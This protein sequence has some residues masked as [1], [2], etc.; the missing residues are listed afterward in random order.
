MISPD[1]R[2]SSPLP[3]SDI[4][5]DTSHLTDF[6][7]HPSS[8]ESDVLPALQ[9]SDTVWQDEGISSRVHS[10]EVRVNKNLTVDRVEYFDITDNNGNLYTVDAL[11]KDKTGKTGA[12]DSKVVMFAS[13]LMR[14]RSRF[15]RGRLCYPATDA[16]R[17]RNHGRT[18]SHQ[19]CSARARPE[20][21]R[22]R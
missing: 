8:D 4:P 17:K 13:A 16:A 19:V 2:E 9:K 12:G 10:G 6:D 7:G 18:Q 22:D 5:S 21:H 14:L 11:M 20:V 3:P 15:P 1:L